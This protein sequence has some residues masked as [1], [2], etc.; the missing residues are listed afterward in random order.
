MPIL[1]DADK[2]LFLLCLKSSSYGFKID[3]NGM[4]VNLHWGEFLADTDELPDVE[5]L[6]YNGLTHHCHKNLQSRYELSTYMPKYIY[7]PCLK[8][9]SPHELEELS[10]TCHSHQLVDEEHLVLSL[11]DK[12]CLLSVSLHY[13]LIPEYDLMSR[14]VEIENNSAADIVIENLFSA[15]WAFPNMQQY[16]LTRITGNWGQEYIVTRETMQPGERVFESRTGIS[17]HQHIPFFAID[18]GNATEDLGTVYYGTLMWSGNWKFI[19]EL[20]PYMETKISGGINNFDFELRLAPGEK[21]STPEF[22]GGYTKD[23]FGQMS[24]NI[25]AYQQKYLF[26]NS[27]RNQCMPAIYN[28]YSSIRGEEVTEDNV[29]ALIP[30][31]TKVGIEMF[32]IDAGWQKCMGDWVI[33]ENKFPGGFKKVIDSVHKNGMEF[34]LWIEFERVDSASRIYKEHPEWLLDSNSYSLL[35]FALPEVLEHIYGVLHGLLTENDIRYIKMDLN[36]YLE[37]PNA[38]D[39]RE[40]RTKYMLNFYA[41]LERLQRDFPEVFFENCA[42]GSGRPDLQMDKY[43]ARINRSDNQDTLDILGIHEG[44]TYLHPSKMAGGGCQ[45]SKSYSYFMNHRDIPLRFMAH[46][47][48]MSWLSLGLPVDKS[49]DEELHECAEY[50]KLYK[51]IR[52]IVDYG[53]LYRLVSYRETG[54]F[55]AFEFVL[56][57]RSEAL[58]FVFAHGL[59]YSEALPALRMKSLCPDRMYDITRYGDHF[60]AKRDG[61]CFLETPAPQPT[62]GRSLMVNG[63][64]I[65]LRGDLDS[66]IYHYKQKEFKKGKSITFEVESSTWSSMQKFAIRCGNVTENDNLSIS[67]N[68]K[69][70]DDISIQRKMDTVIVQTEEY[71]VCPDET[72][73]IEISSENGADFWAESPSCI[74]CPTPIPA[75][76][77]YRKEIKDVQ[78]WSTAEKSETI[79]FT[80]D[81]F[82]PSEWIKASPS[83]NGAFQFGDGIRKMA[84]R[85][86]SP[87][88]RHVPF[89]AAVDYF[90]SM[91]VNGKIVTAKNG[92][93]KNPEKAENIIIKLNKGWNILTFLHQSGIDGSSFYAAIGNAGDLNFD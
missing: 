55:A 2:R 6:A 73:C 67:I 58:L 44:F 3:T 90:W 79:E 22:I 47:A 85:V 57:D 43:F 21:F 46:A 32:I 80:I 52:H 8:V 9:R 91:A 76:S 68:G 63:Q 45:I 49:T 88:E 69:K 17:G 14:W 1:V 18:K 41:L 64:R 92:G 87:D 81:N 36:R 15:S 27:M 40:L 82:N 7:E 53:E 74:I 60:D 33:D 10:L 29:L 70:L 42:S 50:I 54:K 20:D 39:R 19:A 48:C 78:L 51:E 12:A 37:I 30:Q 86:W 84:F 23:G 5:E 93:P 25:H 56:P 31:A 26:P 77:L 35:N 59:R 72:V 61:F 13:R 34:G 66:R 4:P 71:P 28:T 65:F 16:R 38:L 75:T 62:T 89:R 83:I 11:I 24:R